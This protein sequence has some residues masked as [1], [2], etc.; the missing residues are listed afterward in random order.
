MADFVAYVAAF[1]VVKLEVD[2]QSYLK[3]LARRGVCQHEPML[4][5]P[6]IFEPKEMRGVP[7]GTISI[8]ASQIEETGQHESRRGSH[9]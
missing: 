8:G 1:L 5:H 7:S 9:S 2:V 6:Y 3:V 4:V